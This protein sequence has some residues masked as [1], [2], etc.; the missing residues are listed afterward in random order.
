[1]QFRP[2]VLFL[3]A[4]VAVSLSIAN[5]VAFL[6]LKPEVSAASWIANKAGYQNHVVLFQQRAVARAQPGAGEAYLPIYDIRNPGFFMLVAEL[7]VRAGATTPLPLEILSIILF[8]VGALCF[9]VWVYLLFGDPIVAAFGTAFLALSQFFLFYPGIIH[10]FPYEFAFFNATLLLF[11]LFLKTSKNG[12]LVG[13]LIAMFMA[14]MNYWSYYMSSWIIMVGLWW[15]YRG[16]PGIKDVAILSAPPIAAAA[17]TAIMVMSLFGAKA[18]AL[19][20]ADILVARTLDVRIPGGAWFPDQRFMDAADWYEYPR[21]VME[22]LEWAYGINRWFL[23]AAGC[24]FVL[25]W[26][27]KKSALVSALILLAGGFSWYYVMFQHTHIHWFVGQ[28]SFMAICTIN[29][30]IMSETAIIIWAA[31]RG[32]PINGRWAVASSKPAAASGKRSISLS[33][34]NVAAVLLLVANSLFAWPYLKTTYGMVNQT[35]LVADTTEA[36]YQKAVQDICRQHSDITL[37][38]LQSA[39]KNWEFEW[40]AALLADANQMPKCS[41]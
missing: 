22:K 36:E 29:G 14:C 13:A 34:V 27:R 39:A 19:R 8:D 35:I 26:F 31:M 28:Y 11:V 37:A 38:D 10:T 25:L 30:L 33:P 12:Y 9:L 23:I 7:F 21:H 4:L 40:N 3:V 1:M 24:T 32:T 15:Q 17:L 16:R 41:S 6:R 20:I 18:G 2:R 5:Y